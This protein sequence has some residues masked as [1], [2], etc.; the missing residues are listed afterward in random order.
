MI[1]PEDDMITNVVDPLILEIY[2][3]KNNY[4]DRI[5]ISE[6]KEKAHMVRIPDQEKSSFFVRVEDVVD[7]LYSSF[8]KDLQ[9]FEN[10]SEKALVKN[11]TSVYFLDNMI[12]SFEHL[13][14]FKVNVSDS[15]VYSRLQKDTI[16]FDYRVIHSRINFPSFCTEEFLEKCK[17]IFESI[18]LYDRGPF[19]KKP[20]FETTASD[21]IARLIR[22]SQNLESDEE[23]FEIDNILMI[24]GSKIEKDNPIVLVIVEN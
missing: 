24:L 18:G 12:K 23:A 4:K 2:L 14:Y 5:L 22:Y 17:N 8:R 13:K 21:L 10:T 6:L 20:Y 19:E 7:V 15:Q 1:N 11:V 3:Y 16:T 9:E